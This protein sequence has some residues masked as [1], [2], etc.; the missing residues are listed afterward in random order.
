M[1][2]LKTSFLWIILFGS[3]IGLFIFLFQHFHIFVLQRATFEYNSSILCPRYPGNPQAKI[4]SVI[5]TTSGIIF[6]PFLVARSVELFLGGRS[7]NSRNGKLKLKD[8][9]KTLEDVE[10]EYVRVDFVQGHGNRTVRACAAFSFVCR[11]FAP[12]PFSQLPM[13]FTQTPTIFC[14]SWSLPSRFQVVGKVWMDVY[15]LLMFG[16]YGFFCPPLPG[17]VENEKFTYWNP[18][19][20]M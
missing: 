11:R 1:L 19:L 15:S 12:G 16:E 2:L 5:A 9:G 14:T 10:S 7:L 20:N 17:T 13:G 3:T 6:I 8:I 4:A 18:L